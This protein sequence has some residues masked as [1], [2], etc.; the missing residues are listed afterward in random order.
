VLGPEKLTLRDAVRRVARVA[1]KK[2]L[3][4]RMP[5][6]FHYILGWMVERMMKTPLV[7]V[8]QVRMLAEGL[9]EPSPP[10][11]TLP[12]ELGLKIAFS[13][14][15][16]RNGLPAAGPFRFRDL[17]CCRQKAPSRPHLHSVFFE[18]P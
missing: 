2:P 12:P 16:I 4:F 10:C 15:Q 8:A 1:G 5:L 6:W 17:R 3:M 13:E 11:A 14:E 7:S 18:M 9:S